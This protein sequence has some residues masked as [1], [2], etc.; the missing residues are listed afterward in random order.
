[1]KK[2]IKTITV[3]AICFMCVSC[4]VED[5][6]TE[7]SGCQVVLKESA[8]ISMWFRLRS[9]GGITGRVYVM[10]IDWNAYEVGDT[11]K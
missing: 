6:H 4:A 1:M 10:E 2:L 11:I 8:P 3:L 7:Y 9:N 5:P